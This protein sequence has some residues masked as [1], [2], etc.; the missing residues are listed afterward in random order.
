MD[1]PAILEYDTRPF[2]RVTQGQVLDSDWARFCALA[3][4]QHSES[5]DAFIYH[6]PMVYNYC[7]QDEPAEELRRCLAAVRGQFGSDI[8][9]ILVTGCSIRSK[10]PREEQLWTI[11]RRVKFL[12]FLLEGL[13]IDARQLEIRWGGVDQETHVV[14]DSGS[15]TYDLESRPHVMPKPITP[16]LRTSEADYIAATTA[17]AHSRAILQ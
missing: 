17:P 3:V 5:P 9:R 2:A 10:D 15:G 8:A 6:C 16:V 12:R 11:N 13:N 7:R 14:Y 1:S 4:I